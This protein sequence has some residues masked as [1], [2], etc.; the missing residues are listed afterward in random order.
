VILL[1][2]RKSRKSNKVITHQ[3]EEVEKQRA[4]TETQKLIIEGKQQ[5]ITDSITYATRIQNAVL[6]P[7]KL[8]EDVFPESFILF[9]PKDIVSGDF[10]WFH[11]H[12][13][14][15]SIAAA[16]CTG[17]GVPGAIMSVIASDKLSEAALHCQDPSG[18][19]EMTNIGIKKSLRQSDREDSTRDG[20]DIAL[21]CYDEE[22]RVLE[23]AGANRPF[24]MIP[25]NSKSLTEIKATKSAIGGL[26][27]DE[28]TFTK[29]TIEVHKGD[30]VYLCSDGFADQFSASN[31]KMMT[32][33][34]KELLVS[35]QDKDMKEQKLFLSDYFNRWKA[36]M[37]QT[38][39]VLVIGIRF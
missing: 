39:D 8:I 3:K 27:K 16:D 5:E 32:G 26:T 33:K 24:W 1:S 9:Q 29:H 18:I 4:I 13:R 23:Y 7:I 10:Y 19:L 37:E 31:K 28:Q 2:L 21:C 11:R 12:N 25:K 34:F 22:K 14:G 35:V 6:P 36:D 17:H 38:D 15:V 30:T 20:M